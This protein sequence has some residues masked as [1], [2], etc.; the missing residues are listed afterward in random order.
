M[1]I[2]DRI[3]AERAVR[4]DG[5][6]EVPAGPRAQR[7]RNTILQAALRLFLEQGYQRTTMAEVAA[8]AGVSLGAVYQYFRDR[9]DLVAAIIQAG[10]RTLVSRS[11]ITWRIVEGRPGL[12]R[13]LTN[14]A[15]GYAEA[16]EVAR[17]WDE[18]CHVDDDLAELR[19]TLGRVFERTIES[20]L[21][22]AQRAGTVRPDLDPRSAAR[23]LAGMADRYC[24]VTYVFDPPDGAAPSPEETGRLLAGLWLNAVGLE[25]DEP[26]DVG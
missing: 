11:D 5:G 3:F 25:V 2:I 19:R 23:A 6:R 4:R 18:V 16:P 17:V 8:A 26:V 21:R 24:Y 13:V 20:E 10:L 14:Y 15:S 1:S 7:T 22:R 9:S 12:E